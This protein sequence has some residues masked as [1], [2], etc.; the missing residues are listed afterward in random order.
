MKPVPIDDVPDHLLSPVV[1]ARCYRWPHCRY[2][3]QGF[4]REVRA[5]MEHHYRTAHPLSSLRRR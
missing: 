1:T 5:T 2:E 3:Q 4:P